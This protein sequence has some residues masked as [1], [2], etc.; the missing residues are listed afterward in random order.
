MLACSS[1]ASAPRSPDAGKAPRDCKDNKDNKDELFL[2]L[3]VLAVPVVLAV[4]CLR[5]IY[6]EHGSQKIGCILSAVSRKMIPLNC[7]R[8]WYENKEPIF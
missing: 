1:A 2:S 5:S 7:R 8:G 6:S 4:P 3:R